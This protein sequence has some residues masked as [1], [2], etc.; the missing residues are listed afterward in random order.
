MRQTHQCAVNLT[1]YVGL[2]RLL[3]FGRPTLLTHPGKDTH[4]IKKKNRLSIATLI[5]LNRTKQIF[6]KPDG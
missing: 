5:D 1:T 4:Y 2:A 3:V 6:S